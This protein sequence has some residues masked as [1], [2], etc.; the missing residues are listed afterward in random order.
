[1]DSMNM[2]DDSTK[3][4]YILLLNDTLEKKKKLLTWLITITKQQEE[5]I[6][7]DPFDEQLFYETIKVKEKHLEE[8]EQLDDGFTKIYNG[9]STELASN[10][11]QYTTIVN[12]L[13]ELITEVTEMG[14]EI[15]ALEK[16]NK[17]KMEFLFSQKR[18]NIRDSRMS[19]KSVTSY[20][21][22]MA[23]QHDNNSLFYDKKK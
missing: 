5:I 14:I 23:K 17:L 9:V 22:N 16:R 1:M 6:A 8:L 3:R 13:K 20:Y 4:A 15:Q 12:K 21:K 18:K 2:S 19:S 10:R 11:Q 7:T